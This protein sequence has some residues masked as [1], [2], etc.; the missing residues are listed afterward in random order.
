M[1]AYRPWLKRDLSDLIN[2]G[3]P[4]TC[5]FIMLNPSTADDDKDDPTIRRCIG[6]AKR[7]RLSRLVVINLFTARATDPADLM[8]L[9]DPV[10]PDG[11]NAIERAMA[12]WYPGD[13][14]SACDTMICAWGAAHKNWPAWFLELRRDQIEHVN[15]WSGT[16]KRPLFALGFTIDGSPRHPLYVSASAPLSPMVIAEV[17]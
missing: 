5:Y 13:D 8:R 10:G 1:T 2:V 15:D 16:L 3:K 17:A 7:L 11:A 12:Q 6:F 9:D 4:G 14:W